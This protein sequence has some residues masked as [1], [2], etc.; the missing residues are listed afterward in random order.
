MFLV[1]HTSIVLLIEFAVFSVTSVLT[2]SNTDASITVSTPTT[3][4]TGTS[5]SSGSSSASILPTGSSAAA[6]SYTVQTG[7]LGFFALLGFVLA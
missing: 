6:L 1:F 4:L 3:D 5:D 7:L 2:A